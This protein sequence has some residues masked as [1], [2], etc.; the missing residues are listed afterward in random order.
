MQPHR[1]EVQ[2]DSCKHKQ[3]HM[4]QESIDQPVKHHV[5]CGS[6]SHRD[7]II[8][9]LSRSSPSLS[10][11]SPAKYRIL[12]IHYLSKICFVRGILQLALVKKTLLCETS[13]KKLQLGDVKS[14]EKQA[15]SCE[16]SFENCKLKLC[17]TK[18]FSAFPSSS[19][20]FPAAVA[21][22]FLS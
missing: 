4:G 17:K 15:F 13:F 21:W 14:I 10:I 19:Q 1:G 3:S 20:L 5:H 7:R 2:A 16:A 8:S 18:L 9:K 11:F 6:R 22:K 12:R